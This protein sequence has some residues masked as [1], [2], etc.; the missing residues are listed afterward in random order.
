M[1]KVE[2]IEKFTYAKYEEIKDTLKRKSVDEKG[3]LFVG[4]T[5]ECDKETVEYLT[6]GNPL[7]KVVVKVIEVEPEAPK[8]EALTDNEENVIPLDKKTIK[9][10]GEAL[11]SC[12]NI[13]KKTIKKYNKAPKK[14]KGE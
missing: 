13:D 2:V 1:I 7:G 6:G 3:M 5:F 10:M 4:D 9:K 11:E 12:L 14:K 8:V